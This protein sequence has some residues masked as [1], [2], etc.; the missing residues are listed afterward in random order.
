MRSGSPFYHF[1]SKHELL[2]RGDGGR[3][4]GSA[5]SA[6][7]RSSTSAALDRGRALPSPRPRAL[8]HP[9]RDRQRLHPGDALRLA[10]AAGAAP[11]PH[12]RAEGPLRRD[13]AGDA[14]RAARR[15][16]ARRRRAH[17]AP[18]DPRRD[19]L[20]GD[21]VPGAAARPARRRPRHARRRRRPPSSC[22]RARHDD[23]R[24]HRPR[25][26]GLDRDDRSPRGPQCRRRA[27]GARPRRRVSRVR[28]R[29]R[30]RASPFS[31]APA[32]TSAPAPTCASVARGS[33]PGELGASG[34]P[35]ARRRHGARRADGTDA[36][37]SSTKPVIAAV[38]GYAVAGGLELAL[39]CDLRVAAAT[40]TF[41]VFCR[42]FGVPLDRRRHGA[43]AAPHRREPGDGSDPH[44]PR[45][46]RRGGARDR[47][48]QSRR[49]RRARRSQR[50]SRS[51]ARSPRFRS[52]ACATIVSARA[53]STASR[54][55]EAL[56]QE[57]A[58]GRATIDSGEAEGGARRFVAGAGKHGRFES[59]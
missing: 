41:G 34:A 49:R 19:Q 55:S 43:P 5:S 11:A 54:R 25:R 20:L 59:S 50:R 53:A 45:R 15:R 31:P 8:R 47:P 16:Q 56:A 30:S 6:R 38:E 35:R 3:P 12:R 37:S 23:D 26:R 22:A 24:S 4:A 33:S 1:A 48:R 46:R 40:A 9:A 44:R 29:C 39:W 14:R 51:R 21:V 28:R 42:R 2:A 27:D 17:R 57:F 58:L 10:I 18:D 7:A 36:G 32:A 13:L 52:S